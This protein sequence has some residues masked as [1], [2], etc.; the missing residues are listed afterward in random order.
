MFTLVAEMLS[1]NPEDIAF[2]VNLMSGLCTAFAAMFVC[3]ITVILGR[4]A[5]VGRENEP[6]QAQE[7]ALAGAGIAAGLS[8]AFAA[9]I[10]FSAVEGEVY[11][12]STFFTTL[13]VWAGVKW[14][15]LPD[16]KESDR[17]LIFCIFAAALRR[18][19][20]AQPADLS[21][22]GDALLLQEGCLSQFA[23]R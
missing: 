11:A 8:T 18:G 4:I 6:D 19:T 10:W 13:V 23:G 14:Y 22:L 17:W 21:C 1:D 15:N 5:L 3:W 16:D 20:L 12:M 7:I 2:A 9:S